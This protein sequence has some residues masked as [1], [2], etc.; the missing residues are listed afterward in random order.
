MKKILLLS[1][2]LL[3]GS[4]LAGDAVP[5]TPSATSLLH[6]ADRWEF[7]LESG[8]LWETGSN[9]SINYEIVPTQ[10]TFR[11]PAMW[12][13]F[14]KDDGSR[15][16]LRNRFALITESITQGPE[17]YYI[18]LSAAPSFEYWFP[19]AKTSIFCSVGG[20]I[21][22]T[23]STYVY[24]GLGQDFTLNWFAQLGVR[25]EI[26]KNLSILGGAYFTHHSNGGM[27]SPNPGIDATGFTVGIGWQF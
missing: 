5:A 2:A 12:S 20:G 18:G 19:G 21:G 8:Y 11:S 13:W 14:A 16:V 27:T 25:H 22:L 10:F 7:T 15:F 1:L 9:T 6:P 24:D 3:T 23:D 17:D 4:A 26:A